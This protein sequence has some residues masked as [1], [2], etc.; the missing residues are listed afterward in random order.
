MGEVYFL[1]EIIQ[2]LLCSFVSTIVSS[3]LLYFQLKLWW[4]PRLEVVEFGG[5]QAVVVWPEEDHHL[6][7]VYVHQDRVLC[8]TILVGMKPLLSWRTGV[9]G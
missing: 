6:L 2:A 7:L 8:G 1:I 9:I 4:I 3:T 5:F